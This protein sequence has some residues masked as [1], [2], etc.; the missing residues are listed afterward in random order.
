MAFGHARERRR[1]R[2]AGPRAQVARLLSGRG[3]VPL[4]P[5]V[6]AVMEARLGADFAGVR[7]HTGQVAQE[8][9]QSLDAVAYTVGRDVAFARGAFDPRSSGGRETLAHELA[10]VAQSGGVVAGGRSAVSGPLSVSE[11]TD[12]S[13]RQASDAARAV[14]SGGFHQVVRRTPESAAARCGGTTRSGRPC[15]EDEPALHVRRQQAPAGPAP[16]PRPTQDPAQLSDAELDTEYRQVRDWLLGHSRDESGYVSLH[17]CAEALE[18][19]MYRRAGSATTVGGMPS[20]GPGGTA[21]PVVP[22]TAPPPPSPGFLPQKGVPPPP[23]SDRSV[24]VT[25]AHAGG[26][27]GEHDLPFLLGERGFRFVITSSGPG[28]H[29]LTGRGIDAIAFHPENGELWLIDNKASGYADAVRGESATAL[30]VNLGSSLQEAAE[31]VR[32]MPEFPEKGQV[33]GRLE[34]ALS[35]VRAKKAIPAEIKVRLKVTN[36]GGYVSGARGLPPGVEFEDVVGPGVRQTRKE[37]MAKAGTAG[38]K[39]GRPPSHRET[40][41]VRRR[42]GGAMSRQPL[43][44]PVKVRVMRGVRGGGI[45]LVKVVGALVWGA[46]AARIR[47]KWEAE[48]IKEWVEPQLKAMEPEIQARMEGGVEELIDLQLGHLGQPLYAVV[49]V[50]T[51]VRRRGEGEALMEADSKLA[52]VKFSAER[53]ERTETS[54]ETGGSRWWTGRWQ[55]DVTLTTYSI[56]LE[57]FTEEELTAALDARISAEEETAATTSASDSA[58]LASQRRRNELLARRARLQAP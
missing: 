33:L 57:P 7:I 55:N 26:A 15:A 47:Q 21:Q 30:G 2:G 5:G 44:V 20:G 19:E 9:A 45:G 40:E 43:K 49:A 35:A 8:A 14:V 23:A 38:V 32:A 29:K 41:A 50:V 6:R 27:Y 10:H 3:G 25:A 22:M 39:P 56:E 12:A 13:E 51:T 34:K 46:L 4:E 11:P 17:T 53:V 28:A 36:A 1:E 48:K 16:R 52:S 54:R 42:V 18:R 37:D 31:K 24:R 58:V